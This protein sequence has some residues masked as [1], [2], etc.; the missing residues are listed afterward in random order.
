ML[1]LQTL[2]FPSIAMGCV[3]VHRWGI[4]RLLRCAACS[5]WSA[6]DALDAAKRQYRASL[7]HHMRSAGLLAEVME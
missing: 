6:A 5:L 4:A 2:F 1:I 7:A 3:V